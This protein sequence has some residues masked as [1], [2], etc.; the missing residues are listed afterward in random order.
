MKKSTNGELNFSK[1]WE[2]KVISHANVVSFLLYQVAKSNLKSHNATLKGI[3]KTITLKFRQLWHA[4]EKNH[5]Y[6]AMLI[7]I[8]EFAI[9]AI[10]VFQKIK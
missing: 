9:N 10:K 6:A 7:V 2:G 5:L 4:L 3:Y 8:L 1:Q